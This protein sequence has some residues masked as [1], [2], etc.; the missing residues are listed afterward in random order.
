[1]KTKTVL[2]ALALTLVFTSCVRAQQYDS[3]SD[4]YYEIQNGQVTITGY[5]GSKQEIRIPP[6]IRR[7]PV[8]EIGD[9]YSAI[10]IFITSVVIPDSVTRIG[11][12]AFQNNQLTNVVIPDSVTTIGAYAFWQSNE[13]KI[14]F[15]LTSVVIGNG[16]TTIGDSAFNNNG[17][18]SV[19][20]GNNVKTIGEYAFKSNRLTSVVIPDSVTTIGRKAFIRNQ[21][22]SVVI[23][24]SVTTIEMEAFRDNQLTSIIIPNSVTTI[25]DWAFFGNQLTSVTIGS[26]VNGGNIIDSNFYSSYNAQGR[27]AGT[28]TYSNRRWSRN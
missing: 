19:T 27:M 2:F 4:F 12:K 17:L 24:D 6:Q 7:M 13:Q 11:N 21:L 14:G 5:K 25:G 3:E 9:G 22:T 23:P 8:T 10:S 20:I 26:N 16:V 28:Y 18:T 15:G 1:M